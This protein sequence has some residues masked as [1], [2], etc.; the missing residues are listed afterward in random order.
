MTEELVDSG[1][2]YN[3]DVAFGLVKALGV[4]FGDKDFIESKFVGFAD[5][6]IDAVYSPYFA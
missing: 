6:C 2:R 5:A 1:Y 3:L 4:V